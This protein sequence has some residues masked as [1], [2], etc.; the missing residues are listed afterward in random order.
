MSANNQVVIIGRPGANPEIK[1]VGQHKVCNISLAVSRPGKD[2][3]GQSLTDW[4]QCQFWNRQAEVLQQ[5][6]K[7]GDLISVSGSL[8]TE[9]WE[10]DGQKRSKVYIAVQQMQMLG[11]PSGNTDKAVDRY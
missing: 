5:Y 7:K 1:E 4:I 9:S 11:S 6:V 2:E 10:K 8:R 3:Y